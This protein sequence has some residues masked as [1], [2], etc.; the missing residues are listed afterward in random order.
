MKKA[1]ILFSRALRLRCPACGGGPLFTGWFKVR[2][3]CPGCG[4]ALDRE[5]GHFVGAMAFNLIAS[6]LL[7]LS[8]L[9]AVLALTWPNPPWTA[10]MIGSIVAM[11]LFPIMF[12]PFSRTLWYAFDLL[13]QPVQ[14]NEF[15]RDESTPS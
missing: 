7:W 10:V 11:I 6:E 9:V 1:L 2:A 4:L 13:F 8:G 12:Y 3:R 5:E 14:R 15:P